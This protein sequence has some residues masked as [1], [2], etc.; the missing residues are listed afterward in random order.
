MSMKTNL[1][2][3][4]ALLALGFA[5]SSCVAYD[6]Y[7]Y[8]GA[9]PANSG[10]YSGGGYDGYYDGVGYAPAYV[11]PAY[12]SVSVGYFG[13]G[14]PFFSGYG[15]SSYNNRYSGYGH[16][17]G[18]SS[19]RPQSNSQ[20]YASRVTRPSTFRGSPVMSSPPSSPRLPAPRELPRASYSPRSA[21]SPRS[22]APSFTPSAPRSAPRMQSAPAPSGRMDRPMNVTSRSSGGSMAVP[23]ERRR[24]R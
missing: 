19:Y 1:L 9:A 6:E 23:S 2:R 13:G 4:L 5:L 18:H 15:R 20:H 24:E 21:P 14:S 17:H 22:S 10:Y 3:P 12:S 11:A 8:Y 16:G 7:G